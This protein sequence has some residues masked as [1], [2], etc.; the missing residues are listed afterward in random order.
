MKLWPSVL[1]IGI[2]LTVLWR[3]FKFFRNSF[4]SCYLFLSTYITFLSTYTQLLVPLLDSIMFSDE[5]WKGFSLCV[6]LSNR[7]KL[8][9]K[10]LLF[11]IA[12]NTLKVEL[13]FPFTDY[14]SKNIY[15]NQQTQSIDK[16]LCFTECSTIKSKKRL[17][18]YFSIQSAE[19]HQFLWNCKCHSNIHFFSYNSS[20]AN[21]LLF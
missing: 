2:L 4:R 9:G 14:R 5:T 18:I 15:G 6:R 17:T 21:C 11:N 12:P 3:V 10:L 13:W 16:S 20:P 8:F 7:E 19:F 1:K